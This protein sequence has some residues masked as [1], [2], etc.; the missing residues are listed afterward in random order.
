MPL[1]WERGMEKQADLW[2]Q[3]QPGIHREFQASQAS[4]GWNP[5]I[6]GREGRGVGRKAIEESILHVYVQTCAYQTT[7]MYLNT[8]IQT[9]LVIPSILGSLVSITFL[10]P[11]SAPCLPPP[12]KCVLPHAILLSNIIVTFWTMTWATSR[13][14]LLSL[15]WNPCL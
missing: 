14:S 10:F 5:G 11:C 12:L 7:H 2:A 8:S 1:F 13:L 9:T 4:L 15:F 6:W 3:G